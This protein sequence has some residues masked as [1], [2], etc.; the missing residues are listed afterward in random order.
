MH[1]IVK[2]YAMKQFAN[3]LVLLHFHFIKF[4]SLVSSAK[5]AQVLRKLLN[6]QLNLS[7]KAI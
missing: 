1:N 4:D 6:K 5:N 7:E 3:D 2:S